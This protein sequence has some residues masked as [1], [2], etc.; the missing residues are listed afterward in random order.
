MMFIFN[1][2]GYVDSRPLVLLDL[3]RQICVMLMKPMVQ[4]TFYKACL[5]STQH[6]HTHTSCSSNEC[7]QTAAPSSLPCVIVHI[8]QLI[9]NS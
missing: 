4:Y 2:K 1:W 3:Y 9:T 6:T 8:E 7:I 5:Q